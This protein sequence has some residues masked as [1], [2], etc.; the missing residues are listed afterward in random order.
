MTKKLFKKE[1]LGFTLVEA[2]VAIAILM[3]AIATPISLAQKSL[4]ISDLSKDQMTATFLA[5]DGLEAIKNI[6]D[7]VKSN[8]ISS[9]TFDW[10]A[11]FATTP[12]CICTTVSTCDLSN[13]TLIRCN[14]DTTVNDL[15]TGIRDA[16]FNPL[17]IA[18]SSSD[19][20]FLNYN[21]GGITSNNTPSK[22]SRYINI[23]RPAISGGNTDEAIA[24]V[25]VTWSSPQGPQYVEIKS[26]IYNY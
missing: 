19:G 25:R 21:L 26:F 7:Q 12:S 17:K 15:T 22:F 20:S 5:Q 1:N 3:I 18:T 16:G 6:R 4:T 14:I 10:L 24:K 13:A 2:L 23:Q 9:S 8:G 11:P